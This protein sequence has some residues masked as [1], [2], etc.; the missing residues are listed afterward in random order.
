MDLP[1]HTGNN[2][3]AWH[4]IWSGARLLPRPVEAAAM[5]RACRPF[6][7]TQ[8]C[9]ERDPEWLYVPGWSRK[10]FAAAVPVSMARP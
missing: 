4:L 9:T 2:G 8:V 6:G 10:A 7:V 5:Q 3:D 1:Q